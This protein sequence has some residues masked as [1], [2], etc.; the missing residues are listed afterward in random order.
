MWRAESLLKQ[1][2]QIEYGATQETLNKE[3]INWIQNPSRRCPQR[4]LTNCKKKGDHSYGDKPICAPC[5]TPEKQNIQWI[6][7]P[8]RWC[9]QRLLTN[10]KKEGDYFYGDK[11]ICNPCKEDFKPAGSEKKQEDLDSCKNAEED[12][13]CKS[14]N[15]KNTGAESAAYPELRKCSWNNTTKKCVDL[16]ED[17][18]LYVTEQMGFPKDPDKECENYETRHTCNEDSKDH[19]LQIQ[20]CTWRQPNGGCIKIN[21]KDIQRRAYKN[22]FANN[23]HI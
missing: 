2:E 6:Q 14:K 12:D 13:L 1:I 10:C 11:P 20:K 18:R 16:K 21:D 3:S 5:K 4:L 7:N 17:M 23:E 9:S 22:K 8:S 15:V 19:K